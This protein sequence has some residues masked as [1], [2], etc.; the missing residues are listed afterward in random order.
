MIRVVKPSSK[1]AIEP[2]PPNTPVRGRCDYCNC[3]VEAEVSDC[4]DREWIASDPKYRFA[5]DCP[6]P[7]CHGILWMQPQ[8]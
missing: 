7:K 4:R 2:L 5:L 6:T 3:E 1:P 8:R